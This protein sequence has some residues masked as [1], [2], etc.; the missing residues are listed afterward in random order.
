VLIYVMKDILIQHQLPNV[1]YVKTQLI[2]LKKIHPN[3]MNVQFKMEQKV[4]IKIS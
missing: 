3:A 1:L 4:A 2:I